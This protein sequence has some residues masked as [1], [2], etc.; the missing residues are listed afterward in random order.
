MRRI[1]VRGL[2]TGLVAA[3]AIGVA[4]VGFTGSASA[5]QG[6]G[7]NTA[8]IKMAVK[9]EKLDFFGPKSVDEGQK[10]EV[11]NKTSVNRVGPHTFTLVDPNLVDTG[12]ERK[13]CERLQSKLCQN[14][15]E[16]H[17]VGPPPD[18]PVGRPN[19]DR[20]KKGWDK[21]FTRRKKGDS[22]FTDERG[23]SETRKVTADAGETLGYF[24]V[25]H[26]FMRGKLKVE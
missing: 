7:A 21:E 4:V 15:L 8:K 6:Q 1:S 10:L 11:V 9:G 25:V 5:E 3:G 18:F 13:K 16:A 24:C 12:K 2:G 17:R 26:P 23:A 22:W 14:I 20:G 19:V